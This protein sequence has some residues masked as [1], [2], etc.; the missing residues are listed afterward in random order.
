MSPRS[1]HPTAHEVGWVERSEPINFQPS[2]ENSGISAW[3][4][5]ARSPSLWRGRFQ[6]ADKESRGALPRLI[7]VAAKTQ[8]A[9]ESALAGRDID[10]AAGAGCLSRC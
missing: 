6:I 4:A 2:V 3:V 5:Q 1:T 9:A 10:N 8:H 7:R